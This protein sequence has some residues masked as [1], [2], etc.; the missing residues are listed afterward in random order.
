M[1]SA[2]VVSYLSRVC[3]LSDTP[4]SPSR[5][6]HYLTVSIILRYFRSHRRR[7][8]TYFTTSYI[9]YF[10]DTKC[11][12]HSICGWTFI[13]QSLRR[14]VKC[15]YCYRCL[16]THFTQTFHPSVHPLPARNARTK[17]GRKPKIARKVALQW[18]VKPMSSGPVLCSKDQMSKSHGCIM[19][20]K[21]L[22]PNIRKEDHTNFKSSDLGT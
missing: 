5:C 7:R 10:H 22:L 9:G 8:V 1:S 6:S 14:R 12:E 21:Q 2:L 15:C 3:D 16:I 20:R 17:I 19:Q 4:T 18:H 13:F 11:G